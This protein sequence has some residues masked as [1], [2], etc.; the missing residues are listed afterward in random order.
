MRFDFHHHAK[1]ISNV[2]GA[3]VLRASAGEDV[4]TFGRQ[5]AQQRLG[6]LIAAV[7]A[8]ERAEQAQFQFVRLP[9]QPLQ[10]HLVLGTG[11]R[12][13][14]EGGLFHGHAYRIRKVIG[15]NQG[16]AR[17]VGASYWNTNFRSRFS[18]RWICMVSSAGW[19]PRGNSNTAVTG[20]PLPT[21]R[22]DS[23]PPIVTSSGSCPS[24]RESFRPKSRS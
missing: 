9:A 16:S 15:R 3:R 7:F 23:A 19:A 11:Q 8:P 6:V 22:G 5:Q 20:A 10:D 17:P 21:R 12:D 18:P 14:I 24:P 13:Y 2:H 1:A 4:R